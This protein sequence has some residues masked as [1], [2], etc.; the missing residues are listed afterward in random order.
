MS[1][2]SSSFSAA[3][4]LVVCDPAAARRTATAGRLQ[5]VRGRWR[6]LLERV[7][8]V[9]AVVVVAV[10]TAALLPVPHCR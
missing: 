1:V 7:V 2:L 6:R 8:E 3:T 4:A 9:P 10:I 5:D